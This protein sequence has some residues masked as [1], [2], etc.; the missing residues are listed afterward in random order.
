MALKLLTNR[1]VDFSALL[2]RVLVA[3]PPAIQLAGAMPLG[4]DVIWHFFRSQIPGDVTAIAHLVIHC[5]ER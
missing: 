3:M 1:W 4:P 2:S 5:H